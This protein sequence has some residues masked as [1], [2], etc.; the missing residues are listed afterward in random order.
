MKL[1]NYELYKFFKEKNIHKLY[2][3]NTVATSITFI[4][5][6]GLL[7]RGAVEKKGL[8]QT[9][10][11]SDNKD[12]EI[13]VWDDVFLDTAD[14]HDFF[15]RQNKY[16]PVLFTFDVEFLLKN[17]VDIWITKDNPMYW[18]ES[19]TSIDRYFKDVNELKDKWSSIDRQKSMITI[20]KIS[21]AVLF[22]SLIEIIVDNPNKSIFDNVDVFDEMM[23]AL[24]QALIKTNRLNNKIKTRE[25]GH[26]YCLKNY[27]NEKNDEELAKLFLPKMYLLDS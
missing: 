25:C 14:L 9:S 10:Q 4:Q 1:D 18:S 24:N 22:K 3:A 8:Y 12:K 20:R 26:C 2:H 13:D 27:L 6:E 7:S 5:E 19:S 11:K 23:K 15:S 21:N 17:E 16:G